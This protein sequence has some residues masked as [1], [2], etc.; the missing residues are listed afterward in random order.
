VSVAAHNSKQYPMA[1]DCVKKIYYFYQ[2]FLQGDSWLF[3]TATGFAC[4]TLG[5][6][7]TSFFC[8]LSVSLNAEK[9]FATKILLL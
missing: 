5:I 4:Q 7:S 6:S 3:Q 1:G 9:A 2:T 8:F